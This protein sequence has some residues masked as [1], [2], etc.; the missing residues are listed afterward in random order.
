MQPSRRTIDA[1]ILVAG[2]MVLYL[3]VRGAGQYHREWS[4]GRS[5]A[6]A[7]ALAVE[8]TTRKVRGGCSTH[9]R[10]EF[11]PT[12]SPETYE[13]TNTF[14][15]T[16]DPDCLDVSWSAG[17]TMQVAYVPEDQT[18]HRPYWGR[19]GRGIQPHEWKYSTVLAGL[20]AMP[21]AYLVWLRRRRPSNPQQQ[22]G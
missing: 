11:K 20:F 3:G 16:D 6:V 18:L 1:A 8:V 4:L 15:A 17:E 22:A 9:V 2:L 5:H 12:G 14:L 19:L 21:L 10:F 7:T 13:T